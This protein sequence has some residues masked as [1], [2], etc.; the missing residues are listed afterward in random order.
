M[1]ISSDS[2]R[3]LFSD[4]GA[5]GFVQILLAEMHDDLLGKVARF[6]QLTDLS[7]TLG[8]GGTMIHG[9]EVAY[10]AWTE[11]RNSFIH[12]NYIATVMLCQSLAENLLAAYI[13]TDLE[14]EKLPK[15]VSFND[16]IRRCVSKGVF[17]KSFSGELIT[18]MNIRNP[19]SHYR[20]LEDPSNLSRRVL[21]SRLPAIAHLMGDASFALAIAIK[22]LSLP[23]FWLSGET[24]K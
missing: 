11:A 2:Q 14:A 4:T 18:M 12:G 9:G 20:D 17:D 7:K 21:D 23:P 6:R 13:D 10:T 22:L 19:L 5:L 8:P 15:R 24:L 1:V 3:D 16:T